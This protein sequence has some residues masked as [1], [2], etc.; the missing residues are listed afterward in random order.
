MEG[1]RHQLRHY[2]YWLKDENGNL[3]GKGICQ[4]YTPGNA[5][6]MLS[7]HDNVGHGMNDK[8]LILREIKDINQ[9]KF[10]F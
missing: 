4:G 9:L 6:A 3:I 1:T 7:V 2:E 10:E 5:K 8:N